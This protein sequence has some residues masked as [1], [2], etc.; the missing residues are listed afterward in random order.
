MHQVTILDSCST[1]KRNWIWIITLNI[2]RGL[3]FK[4]NHHTRGQQPTRPPLAPS[5]LTPDAQFFLFGPSNSSMSLFLCSESLSLITTTC[6]LTENQISLCASVI[7][8][9]YSDYEF[10]NWSKFCGLTSLQNTIKLNTSI[11]ELRRTFN[12][13]MFWV[14]TTNIEKTILSCSP[15]I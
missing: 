6:S 7:F 2:T 12:M 14:H 15:H 5:S 1:G 9:S 10:Q 4:I 3:C 13:F 8:Q 11:P